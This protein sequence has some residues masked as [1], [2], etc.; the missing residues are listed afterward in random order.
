MP[1]K[2]P[3]VTHS[4]NS[5]KPGW[6]RLGGCDGT[7]PLTN[8]GDDSHSDAIPGTAGREMLG[9]KSWGQGYY[10]PGEIKWSDRT[11]GTQG[12]C[13]RAGDSPMSPGLPR[14]SPHL[15]HSGFFCQAG[16]EGEICLL[17]C[18]CQETRA[19]P[20]CSVKPSLCT[21]AAPEPCTQYR[22]S[23][24]YRLPSWQ[25]HWVPTRISPGWG[26]RHGPAPLGTQSSLE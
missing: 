2:A 15:L 23:P 10:S 11:E 19:C 7:P 4:P 3:A 5:W 6:I 8:K 9:F 26:Q 21:R 13:G 24:A 20:R 1:P 16:R 22:E 12:V 17:L 25:W 18:S 14:G